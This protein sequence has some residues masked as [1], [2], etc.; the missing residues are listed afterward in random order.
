MAHP[1]WFACAK[2]V[3]RHGECNSVRDARLLTLWAMRDDADI[4][5]FSLDAAEFKWFLR[6]CGV[7]YTV[8]FVG[9]STGLYQSGF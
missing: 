9:V 1:L 8:L 3:S 7:A 4:A 5:V 2:P 6:R